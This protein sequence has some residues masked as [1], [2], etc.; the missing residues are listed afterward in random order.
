MANRYVSVHFKF[1]YAFTEAL[2]Q[3]SCILLA[4]V[5]PDFSPAYFPCAYV[6]KPQVYLSASTHVQFF[7]PIRYINERIPF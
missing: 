4:Y 6:S 3:Y 2:F 1:R 7:L 5:E